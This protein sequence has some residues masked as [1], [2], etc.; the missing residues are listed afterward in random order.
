MKWNFVVILIQHLVLSNVDTPALEFIWHFRS[1]CSQI[2]AS[3]LIL[4][5]ILNVHV[6]FE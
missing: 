1:A 5:G 6:E 4:Q 3:K 2:I